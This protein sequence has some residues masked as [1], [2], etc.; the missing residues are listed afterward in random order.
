MIYKKLK[1]LLVRI[2]GCIFRF[3]L[4][5]LHAIMAY[6]IIVFL[7]GLVPVNKD[8]EQTPGG[9]K[10]FVGTNG[11]HTDIIMPVKTEIFNWRETVPQEDFVSVDSTYNYVSV[12]WGDKG[13]Y[14]KTP[15]WSDL[16]FSTAFKALFLP[17][18]AAMHVTYIRR[19]PVRNERYISILV[20][21]DQYLKLINFILPYFQKADD[22]S[23]IFIPDAAYGNNDN[24]YEAYGSYNLFNTSNNWTN[25]AL[26]K[27]GVRTA[28]WSPLDKPI[29]LQ[30]RKIR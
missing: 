12:G 7:L 8:F 22:G 9:I 30:L 24:F 17:S 6:H 14:I 13:F 15:T 20:S 4:Y 25:R 10:I 18:D 5:L 29:M 19:V 28:L 3:L 2:F 11:I 21:E 1:V 27:T 26:R 16:T 23:V